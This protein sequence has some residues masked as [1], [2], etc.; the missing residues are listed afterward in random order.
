MSL[1]EKIM[2]NGKNKTAELSNSIWLPNWRM[3]K[4]LD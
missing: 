1:K 3:Q 4:S 2:I